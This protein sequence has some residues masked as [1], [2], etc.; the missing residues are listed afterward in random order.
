MAITKIRIGTRGSRLAL[1]Q[2][3]FV[4]EAIVKK[5]P[6]IEISTTIIK[7]KGDINQSPIPLDT[8]G[9]AWFTQ[10]IEEALLRGEIDLAVH[11]YKDL[12][13]AI[14]QEL[15]VFSV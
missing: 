10:E 12:P 7:T 5:F 1:V 6:H 3:N 2:T 9:K 8:V 11:S 4:T 14:P 13:A 15:M